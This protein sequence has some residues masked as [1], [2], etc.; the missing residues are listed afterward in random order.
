MYNNVHNIPTGAHP[1]SIRQ[2]A[3]DLYRNEEYLPRELE[4]QSRDYCEVIH[5]G[6][7]CSGYNS[8]VYFHGFLKSLFLTRSNPIHFHLLVS[9][10]S[11]KVLRILFKTWQIPLVT[12]SFYNIKKWLKDVRWVPNNHYS[13]NYGL[14]KLIFPKV[15]DLNVTK[16]LIVLDTDLLLNGDIYFLWKIFN[17]FNYKQTIG[18]VENQSQYYLGKLGK[19][20]PWPA[21]GTGFNSG[22]MLYD[23]A[24]LNS[25]KWDTLWVNLTKRLSIVYGQA[26]LGDQD[27]INA[28]LVESP[29]LVYRLPCFWNTQM[30]DNSL[31]SSCYTKHKPMIVHWNSPKKYDVTTKDGEKFRGLADGIFEL[32]GNWFREYP[33]ICEKNKSEE[34]LPIHLNDDDCDKYTNPPYMSF[35]TLLFFR[36]FKYVADDNDI[37]YVTHLSYDRFYLMEEIAKIWTGP[38][39]FSLYITDAELAKVI[40]FISENHVLK[41]RSD[42]AYHAVFREGNLYPIN[43]LRNTGLSN[44]NTPFVFLVDI[45]FIPMK[46]L[47]EILKDNIRSMGDLKQKALIVPAFEVAGNN[48]DIPLNKIQLIDYLNDKKIKP[49]LSDVWYSGHG[50]TDYEKWKKELEPYQVNWKVDFEP[51]VVVKSNVVK[52]DERFLGFGWNKVSHIMELEAQNYEFIVLSDV[53]IIHQPHETSWDNIMFKKSAVY[54]KCLQNLKKAF[55]ASL[56]RKYNKTYTDSNLSKNSPETFNRRRKRQTGQDSST[57]S[58]YDSTDYFLVWGGKEKLEGKKETRKQFPKEIRVPSTFSK[59]ETDYYYDSDYPYNSTTSTNN[60][61]AKTSED[62]LKK[63]TNL[64]SSSEEHDYEYDEDDIKFKE[65]YDSTTSLNSENITLVSER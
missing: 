60:Q 47:F 50:P 16:K 40:Q 56:Q 62:A 43:I 24:K 4:L 48:V 31:S 28:L 22:V 13:G 33:Q 41:V 61:N 63:E 17:D 38:I 36:D 1:K 21:L 64:S 35:R 42:I 37:T 19:A 53:F 52:Y 2:F 55:I 45:D 34:L 3:K 11:E 51:Y 46:N 12:V 14:L 39:S 54:R 8:N 58:L 32:N 30:S 23:L 29:G 65:L 18:M 6:I 7:V 10:E 49:F 44:V 20:H 9:D 26:D 59:K 15:I 5:I 27:I 25:I 57:T